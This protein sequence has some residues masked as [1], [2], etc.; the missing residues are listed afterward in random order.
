MKQKKSI[1]I[2][3]VLLILL[4]LS[5]F[6]TGTLPVTYGNKIKAGEFVVEPPTLICLGFEWRIDGDDNRNATVEVHYHKKGDMAWKEAQPLFRQQREQAGGD[7]TIQEYVI[8]NMFA[9]SIL[10]LEPDTE[11]EC[12]F[13]MLDPD[14]VIGTKQ[15]VVSVRTR[16]EPKPFAGGKILHVYPSDFKGS[17]EKP[18]FVG[19]KSAYEEAEP[20]DI[21]L[22]HAGLYQSDRTKYLDYLRKGVGSDVFGTSR[23]TKSGTAEKPIAIKG[24]GDGEAIF[25]G[26]ACSL[27]F[28]VMGANYLYFEG[29]TF[30]NADV[31]FLTGLKNVAGCSGLTIKKCRF[32]NVAEAIRGTYQGSKNY[33]IADNVIIGRNNPKTLLGLISREVR[34][35]TQPGYPPSIGGPNGSNNAITVAGQGHVVCYNYVANFFDGIDTNQ[36]SGAPAPGQVLLPPIAIDF[37]NNY[38]TNISDNCFETDCSTQNVRVMRNMCINNAHGTL[39]SQPVYGGPVYWIRNIVYHAPDRGALK[40]YARPAGV[41]F[42]HNTFCAEAIVGQP[43]GLGA[44]N[45]HFR[46]NLIL[47]ENPESMVNYLPKEFRGIFFMD[48]YTSYSTAD[49]DGFRPSEGHDMQFAWNSPAGGARSDYKN[50]REVHVFKTLKELCAATGQEC[51]GILVDYDIFQNV[52]KADMASFSKIYDAKDMDFRLKPDS[53]AVDAGCVLPNIN[54][55]FTGKVPD[56]GALEVGQPVPIYGPRP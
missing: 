18:A 17:K 22:V 21:I 53:A 11:Y 27:F 15:K 49:Y 29:L 43:S 47:G 16:P 6:V 48:T 28:D 34:Y 39:S 36:S 10:D 2:S 24:A 7:A 1:I 50:P 25:D 40:L 56:L 13:Q 8:P 3:S 42:Y 44:S 9:G 12:R 20:G 32:E 31:A 37:Y 55:G 33:Y 23:L 19:L 26:N 30:R 52:K 41:I 38:I 54:D 14:G 45:V 46:N 35:D 5:T 51:H 4:G